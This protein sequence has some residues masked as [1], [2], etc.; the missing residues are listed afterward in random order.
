VTTTDED[1]IRAAMAIAAEIAEGRLDPAELARVTAEEARAAFGRVVGPGDE[2]WEL[3]C[4]VARQVLAVGD[5]IQASELAEWTAVYAAKEGVE[6]APKV[7]WI[8]QALAAGDEDGDD[9]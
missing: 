8:E 9:E 5:A 4:D 3:H 7:S 1:A 2:L 6:L